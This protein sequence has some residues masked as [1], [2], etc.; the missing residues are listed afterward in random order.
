MARSFSRRT[1]LLGAGALATS[2]AAAT[3]NRETT[4]DLELQQHSVALPKENS[5]FRGYRI[6]F[7]SDVHLSVFIAN[8]WLELA[9]QT[10]QARG[11]DI[12]LIGGDHI[13]VP[14]PN[15]KKAF[16]FRNKNIFRGRDELQEARD[17][18]KRFLNIV[19][20]Y[21]FPDG[22]YA[23]NGNHDNWNAGAILTKLF[24]HSKVSLLVNESHV[25]RRG[26]DNLEIIGVDD[27]WTG[28]PHWPSSDQNDRNTFR[29][30]LAHNPDYVASIL[31]GEKRR[32]D[33][34]LCGHTHGGQICLPGQKQIIRG[35]FDSR[36][37]AGL[38]QHPRG[39]VLTSNG[40]GLVGVPYRVNCRPQVHC[41]LL[42]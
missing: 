12:L 16:A 6:G 27:L 14:S 29:I 13:W 10:L 41:I 17:I 37:S 31:D 22:I 9:L 39:T 20:D 24:A 19:S 8:E 32:F 42:T 40:L 4:W 26:S 38:Y 15:V 21:Q 1:F 18:F 7:L 30:L 36:L 2:V 23:I 5:A 11:I 3:T 33:L 34:A 35:V 25:L 28:V